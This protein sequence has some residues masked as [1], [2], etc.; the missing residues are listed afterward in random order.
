VRMPAVKWH[1]NSTIQRV[2]NKIDA[3]SFSLARLNY[4]I[5]FAKNK[6]A[7]ITGKA[8]GPFSWRI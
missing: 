7:T 8:S 6:F 4:V 3:F 1:H 5:E 2:N